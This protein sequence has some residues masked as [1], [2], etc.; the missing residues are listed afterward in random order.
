VTTANVFEFGGFGALTFVPAD[1]QI[2][3]RKVAVGIPAR[4]IKD[5]TDEMLDWKTEGT[6][7]YQSLPADMR[8]SWRA[9]EPLRDVP[10][11][12]PN[13]SATFRTW[14]ETPKQE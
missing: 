14:R 5:V 11:D 12:R 10:P 2:P 13:Q 3:D 4:I 9:C 7:L 6:R 1:M 8:R